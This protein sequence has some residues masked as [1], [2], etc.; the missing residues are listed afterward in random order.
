MELPS[1]EIDT[2]DSPVPPVVPPPKPYGNLIILC[3]IKGHPITLGPDCKC[4][5]TIDLMFIPALLA[6]VLSGCYI[7]SLVNSYFSSLLFKAVNIL[8]AVSQ[9]GGY[10]TVALSDPGVVLKDHSEQIPL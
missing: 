7:I 6:F 10:L 1:D 9:V 2:A 3:W 4:S 5:P 8:M